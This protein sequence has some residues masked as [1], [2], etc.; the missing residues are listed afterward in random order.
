LT[1]IYH[2]PQWF[3]NIKAFNS[4]ITKIANG[5]LLWVQVGYWAVQTTGDVR[6]L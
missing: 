1:V 5:I 4:T 3:K 6:D 2:I